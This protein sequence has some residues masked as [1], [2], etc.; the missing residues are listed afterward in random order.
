MM[1]I[2]SL[3]AGGT[4]VKGVSSFFVPTA[5]DHVRINSASTQAGEVVMAVT[6]GWRQTEGAPAW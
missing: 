3:R 1:I 2:N 5:S 6:A 4:A